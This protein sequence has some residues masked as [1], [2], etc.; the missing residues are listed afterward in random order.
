VETREVAIVNRKLAER[1]WPD[2]DAVGRRIK[3][4][5]PNSDNPWLTIVG[6]V[7][8]SRLVGLAADEEEAMFRPLL[9]LRYA[10]PTL[11][12]LVRTRSDPMSAVPSIRAAVSEIDDR[13]PLAGIRTM[14]DILA[15]NLTTPRFRFLVVAS[16][17]SLAIG[18]AGLGIYGVVAQWTAA[19]RREIGV[20]MALGANRTSVLRL[21]MEQGVVLLALGTLL[22]VLGSLTA[23]R[24]LEAFLFDVRSSD[25][26]TT[27]L[28]VLFFSAVT[29]AAALIPARRAA[30]IDPAEALR[31]E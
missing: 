27:I 21:V 1:A 18:L 5:G 8:S 6:V 9:P 25:P 17:T 24:F 19:R 28:A 31:A 11:A 26:F 4:G 13:M 22:G 15:D 29:V 10:Y 7:A 12:L 2:G 3:H 14:A 23:A 16:F 20:R 30:A